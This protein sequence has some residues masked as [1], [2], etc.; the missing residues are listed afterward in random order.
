MFLCGLICKLLPP[1]GAG[2]ASFTFYVAEIAA[3]LWFALQTSTATG[4]DKVWISRWRCLVPK[5]ASLSRCCAHV[6]LPCSCAFWIFKKQGV[7]DKVM[8]QDI[9]A[10]IY[11][12]VLT[13]RLCLSSKSSSHDT[14]LYDQ[15]WRQESPLSF[16]IARLQLLPPWYRRQHFVLVL[17]E[18]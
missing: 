1:L 18:C 6:P 13:L 3:S 2:E 9:L 15:R 17:H 5:F 16:S 11:P 14:F 12:I 10:A 7:S 8:K 4:Q